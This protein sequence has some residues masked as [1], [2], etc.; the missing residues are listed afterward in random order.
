[1]DRVRHLGRE[2]R[3][4][5]VS[6][7]VVGGDPLVLVLDDHAAAL[8]PHQDLVLRVLEVLVRHPARVASRREQRSFVHQVLQV[9]TDEA[10]SAPRLELEV[11]VVRQRHASGVDLEDLEPALEIRSRHD[12]ATVK[13]SRAQQRWI[14][15]VGPVRSSDHD[16]ALVRLE[17]VHLHEQL[18]QSLFAFIVPT[19]HPGPTMAT[20]R[21]DLVDED[22]A[23]SLLLALQEEVTHAGRAHADE[24][25]DEVRAGD[26]EEGDARFAGDGACQKRF[27]RTRR[28]HQQHALRNPS[29][30]AGELLG[31][32][33]ELDDLLEL[34]L[35]L[36]DAR[37]VLERHLMLVLGQ[38]ARLRLPEAHRLTAAALHLADEEDPQANE[39]DQ[40]EPHDQDLSPEPALVPGLDRGLDVALVELRQELA[41]DRGRRRV[42]LELAPI[43]EFT[44]D[45]PF[46]DQDGLDLVGLDLLHEAVVRDRRDRALVRLQCGEEKEH[47][48]QDHDPE[49]EVLVE[50]LIHTVLRS[51]GVSY[52]AAQPTGAETDEKK[53]QGALG[54][55]EGAARASNKLSGSTAP[56]RE[57]VARSLKWDPSGSSRVRSGTSRGPLAPRSAPPGYRSILDVPGLT[58]VGCVFQDKGLIDPPKHSPCG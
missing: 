17:A 10:G 33:E 35:G 23:R 49:G 7:F 43:G 28:T 15:H 46:F 18:V 12:H 50:L 3:D 16:H 21:V 26:R 36:L 34:G 57:W 20:D 24:H 53:L 47:D 56:S 45:V 4:E 52:I 8:G 9:R 19:A 39:Q 1:M 32:A 40:R 58:A 5:C 11:D 14:E 44:L 25:L 37:H 55:D 38:Q 54:F 30:E 2:Q 51:T 48:H 6:R 31:L 27:P 41:I 42:G 29:A 22:D 13:A